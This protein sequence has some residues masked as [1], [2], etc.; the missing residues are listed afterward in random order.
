MFPV[1]FPTAMQTRYD[2]MKYVQELPM[3]R[4]GSCRG[5]RASVYQHTVIQ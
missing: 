2:V 4:P 3:L 5:N 1:M